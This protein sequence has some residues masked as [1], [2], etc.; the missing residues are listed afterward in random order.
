MKRAFFGEPVAE[1]LLSHAEDAGSIPGG[2]TEI[3][4]AVGQLESPRCN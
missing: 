2:S 3:L 1:S 4:R